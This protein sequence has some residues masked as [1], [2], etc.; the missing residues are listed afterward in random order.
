MEGGLQ[1]SAIYWETQHTPYRGIFG[2]VYGG[3]SRRAAVKA[4]AERSCVR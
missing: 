3:K 4:A 1:T 2:G